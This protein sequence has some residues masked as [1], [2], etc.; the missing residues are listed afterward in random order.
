M[1]AE[2]E[3]DLLFVVGDPQ[4]QSGLDNKTYHESERHRRDG[5]GPDAGELFADLCSSGQVSED[6]NG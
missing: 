5:I 4:P 6:T 3:A 1:L 2:V